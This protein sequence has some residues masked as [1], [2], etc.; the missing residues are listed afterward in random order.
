MIA[1]DEVEA[2][3]GSEH[4]ATDPR[5]YSAQKLALL[6]PVRPNAIAKCN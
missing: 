3:P 1:A 4:F 5:A 6:L 2:D